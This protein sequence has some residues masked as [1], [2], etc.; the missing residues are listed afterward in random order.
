MRNQNSFILPALV[1]LG[2]MLLAQVGCSHTP[3]KS[4]D[5]APSASQKAQVQRD[6]GSRHASILAENHSVSDRY[7]DA[8][9]AAEETSTSQRILRLTL[10]YVLR[11]PEGPLRWPWII[12]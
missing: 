12:W 2:L 6:E 9:S 5:A 10:K 8:R 1:L 11:Y 7:W 3:V 4:D